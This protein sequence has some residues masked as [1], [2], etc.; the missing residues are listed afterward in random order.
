[1]RKVDR[2]IVKVRDL[3]S[4][5]GQVVSLT[6][7]VG[8]VARI[9]TRS[10]Y[11]NVNQKLSWNSEVVLTKEAVVYQGFNKFH[12]IVS[13]LFSN[14]KTPTIINKLP[15]LACLLCGSFKIRK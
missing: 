9:M 1:M 3:A 6:P 14:F 15:L 8:S 2:K 5:V 7:C 11:A 10:L 4:V 12:L 13:G